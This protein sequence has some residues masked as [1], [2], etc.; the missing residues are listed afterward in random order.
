ME[1]RPTPEFGPNGA[2]LNSATMTDAL[3]QDYLGEAPPRKEIWPR[4]IDW[5]ERA[6]L[7]M[8][9]LPVW[10]TPAG[11][12]PAPLWLKL[13]ITA[14]TGAFLVRSFWTIDRKAHRRWGALYSL[15][16]LSNLIVN[17]TWSFWQH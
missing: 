1:Q 14:G 7:L 9:L 6:T 11:P 8:L 15:G 5:V 17:Y 16:L 3:K 4:R 10:F 2:V 12:A 13:A